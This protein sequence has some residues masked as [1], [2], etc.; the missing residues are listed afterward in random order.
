MIT[1][2]EPRTKST[3]FLCTPSNLRL[4]A[5]DAVIEGTVAT[6]R[7]PVWN[8]LGFHR[9]MLYVPRDIGTLVTGGRR[10]ELYGRTS[11]FFTLREAAPRGNDHYPV[12]LVEAEWPRTIVLKNGH[13]YVAKDLRK[14]AAYMAKVPEIVGMAGVFFQN[15]N[16]GN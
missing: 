5:Y 10:I 6:R 15:G 16:F 12:A 14:D 13:I 8:E 4:E 1:T 9:E 2:T 3:P 7:D 11:D